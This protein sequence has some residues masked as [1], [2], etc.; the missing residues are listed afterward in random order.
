MIKAQP[1][2]LIISFGILLIFSLSSCLLSKKEQIQKQTED[3]SKQAQQELDAGEFQKAIDIYKGIY[4]K[5]PKDTTVQNEYMKTLEA[6]KARGDIAFQ[7]GNYTFSGTAYEALAKNWSAFA[8]FAPSLSFNL[9]FL[10]KRARTS[11]SLHVVMQARTFIDA[12]EFRKAIDTH[13]E[14]VQ[15]YPQ[16]AAIQSDYLKTMESIK[17]KGDIALQNKNFALA[18][19]IYSNLLRGFPSSNFTRS[20]SFDKKVLNGNMDRCR[21][22]LFE[23]GLKLY[24]AGDLDQA[25]SVWKSILVFDPENQEVKKTVDTAILQS[26]NLEKAK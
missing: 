13:K 7:K 4:Q 2:R 14:L 23:R 8:D 20:L 21:K 19:T 25:I 6:I 16:D 26:K 3:V 5:Y 15:K 17:N 11:R 1:K 10:E 18:G 9:S 12:G 24:R 22:T